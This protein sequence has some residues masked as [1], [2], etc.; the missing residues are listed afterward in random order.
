MTARTHPRLSLYS[1]TIFSSSRLCVFPYHQHLDPPSPVRIYLLVITSAGTL[2]YAVTFG[3]AIASSDSPFESGLTEFSVSS[4][5]CMG[6]FTWTFTIS[7]EASMVISLG[8]DVSL[9]NEYEV[10]FIELGVS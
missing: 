7:V 9:I 1:P 3:I 10:Y 6:G 4:L 2:R 8:K 5:P